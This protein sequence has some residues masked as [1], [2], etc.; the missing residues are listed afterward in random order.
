MSGKFGLGIRIM[1]NLFFVLIFLASPGIS[2]IFFWS[3]FSVM[4]FC[5]S[6]LACL[7]ISLA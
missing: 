2:V 6:L 5:A 7:F 4:F 1:S 3:L